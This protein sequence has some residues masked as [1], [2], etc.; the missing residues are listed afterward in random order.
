MS[1]I[2]IRIA[3]SK[4]KQDNP[5][6]NTSDFVYV[7]SQPIELP[8][9]RYEVAFFSGE[10]WFS[11]HNVVGKTVNWSHDNGSS[12]IT[13]N[14]PDGNYGVEDI[15]A[16]LRKSQEDEAVTDVHAVTGAVIYGIEITPN[17]NTNRTDITIDNTVGSGNTFLLDLSDGG[18]PTNMREFLGWVSGVVSTSG[19]GTVLPTVDGGVDSWLVHADIVYNSYFNEQASSVIHSFKP[20]GRPNSLVTEKPQHLTYIQVANKTISRIRI[21]ITDQNLNVLDFKGE[22]IFLELVIRPIRN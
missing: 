9:E 6:I 2:P 19:S 8:H 22:D 12:W 7:P 4:L 17:Y 3:T 1:S 20:K 21:K 11:T 14:V 16:L 13:I 18:D 10:F 5:N 15:N